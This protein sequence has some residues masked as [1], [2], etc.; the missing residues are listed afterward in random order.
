MGFVKSVLVWLV[1]FAIIFSLGYILNTISS[2]P[3][4][5]VDVQTINVVGQTVFSNK[6]FS[7]DVEVVWEVLK[8]VEENV[9]Y[10]STNT[11]RPSIKL[12]FGDRRYVS[13]AHPLDVLWSRS[14]VCSGFSILISTALAYYNITSYILV[15]RG[16]LNESGHTAVG[17]LVNN[18]FFVLDQ[19]LPPIPYSTYVDYIYYGE[20]DVVFKMY[21]YGNDLMYKVVN[22]KEEV[23][24]VL[25]TYSSSAQEI[26][27]EVLKKIAHEYSLV[28]S[29]EAEKGIN[30]SIYSC[31]YMSYSSSRCYSEYLL[32]HPVF[33][34]QWM[35]LLEKDIKRLLGEWRNVVEV[36]RTYGKGEV[37]IW[38]RVD[39]GRLVIFLSG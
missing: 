13:F 17:V 18:S 33:K 29:S 16:F 6:S 31:I 34:K 8:W 37:K 1:S 21:R 24:S 26:I 19:S 20:P 5:V 9:M 23:G 3:K 2:A 4:P 25:H 30:A 7:S 28:L 32:Y 39:E 15:W 14:G 10:G 36:L 11:S 38:G 27:T 22:L 35:E 12:Y